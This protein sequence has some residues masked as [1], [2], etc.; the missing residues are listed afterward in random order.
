MK[1]KEGR[2]NIKITTSVLI[3]TAVPLDPTETRAF[4]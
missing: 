4:T 2:E 3:V 1:E